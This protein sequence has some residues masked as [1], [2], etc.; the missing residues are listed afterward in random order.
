MFSAKAG[1][2]VRAEIH[3][4]LTAILRCHLQVI[5][6]AAGCDKYPWIKRKELIFIFFI[7]ALYKSQAPCCRGDQILYCGV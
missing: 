3:V 7:E 5:F 2:V 4:F 6:S 1:T